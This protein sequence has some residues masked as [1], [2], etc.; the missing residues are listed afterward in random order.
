MTRRFVFLG[1]AIVLGAA[2][3][4][5][6]GGGGGNAPIPLSPTTQPTATAPVQDGVAKLTIVI[7]PPSQQNEHL[8]RSP[9]FV[10]ASTQSMTVALVNGGSQTP[11]PL[12]TPIALVAG[13]GGCTAAAAGG[14]YQCTASITAPQG[15]DDFQVA[16]YA[17][18][19]GTGTALSTGQIQV[20]VSANSPAVTLDLEGVPATVS[21]ALGSPSLKV[22][23]AGTTTI[24]VQAEDSSGNL[25]IGPGEFANPITLTLSGDTYDTLAPQ[26]ASV[27]TPGQVVTLSYDGGTN[28]G[29]TITPS[30]TGITGTP[31]TFSPTGAVM[32]IQQIADSSA[33]NIF[34]PYDVAASTS[35]GAGVATMVGGI[36]VSDEPAESA[37]AV[38]STNGAQA[39]YSGIT[40]DPFATSS[41]P[42]GYSGTYS[43]APTPTPAPIPGTTF[44]SGMSAT[45]NTN[46]FVSNNYESVYDDLAMN[47]TTAYYSGSIDSNQAT[48][49]KFG[50]P[51]DPEYGCYGNELKTG[52]LGAFNTS[53][54]TTVE[55]PLLGYPGPIK[56]DASGNVW[57]V[58][59]YGNCAGTNLLGTD[60]YAIGF[61]PAGGGTPTET[62]LSSILDQAAGS[63]CITDMAIGSGT[64]GTTYMYL[65][66]NC[67][68]AVWQIPITSDGGYGT[69]AE[70]APAD[71]THPT[72]IAASAGGTTY[73]SVV[74]F[75]TSAPD[76]GSTYGLDAY[77]Y[78]TGS[79]TGGFGASVVVQAPFPIV[80]FLSC[81]MTYGDSS[82]WLGNFGN[83]G[84]DGDG[85]QE[86]SAE[87]PS[88]IARMSAVS[89][90]TPVIGY[91]AIPVTGETVTGVA[92]AGGY[93]WSVDN[94]EGNIQYLQYGAPA[95][96]TVAYTTRRIGEQSSR[97]NTHPSLGHHFVNP[98][99]RTRGRT[100]KSLKTR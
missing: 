27:T 30:G 95:S 97:R 34:Y 72:A 5:C 7:P 62:V 65:S 49:P 85:C 60:T 70:A 20:A 55:Y 51:S 75:D 94:A 89:S 17:S 14:G 88:G 44:V 64:N 91:Y 48:S 46:E 8:P 80:D 83:G 31:V 73:G 15:T 33:G 98:L 39:L 74:W 99:Q 68:D 82:F 79:G 63:A 86:T 1:G 53:T 43:P 37:L 47:G 87:G 23:Y 78:V 57:W 45:L 40:T 84:G 13:K 36:A 54:G 96:G 29:T 32:T 58:E 61:L 19:T 25:I 3:Y 67:N 42:P 24:I 59:S 4:A 92:D 16:T 50:G 56:V 38:V 41:P 9:K 52:T 90:G 26:S 2:L 10:S 35:A 77:D 6:G 12:G 69:V 71:S 66:D 28:V 21:L 11:T 81:G 22:G 18:Q 93:L 100:V 76:E